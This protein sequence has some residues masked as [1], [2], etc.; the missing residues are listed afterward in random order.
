MTITNT[1]TATITLKPRMALPFFSRH[2]WVFSKPIAKIDGDPQPGE[3]VTLVTHDGQFVARGLFNPHSA[4]RVRLYSW[5]PDEALDDDF[6]RA[7][8]I[9][10]VDLRRTLFGL[11]STEGCRLVAS[12]GDRL[13]GLTVDRYGE[14]LVVQLTSR[15][16][17]ERK[18]RLI[19]A[20]VEQV[21]PK[22]IWLRT[23]KGMRDAE[24]LDASDGL[25]WGEAPPRPMFLEENDVRFGIDLT[26]GQKT[27][28]FLDQRDNR[29]LVRK[30]ASGRRVLDLCCYSGGFAINAALG[31]AAEVV[32]VDVSESALTLAANNAAL[33]GVGDR[34]RW[35]KGDAFKTLEALREEEKTFDLIVLDPPKLARHRAG[36]D[37]AIRG[38][39]SLNR[40]AVDLVAPGGLLVTCSC[41][42]LV[43]HDMF[44]E[45][46]SKVAAQANRHIQILE[47]RGPSADHPRSV[48]CHES[49]YLKCYVCRVV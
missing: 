40:L 44:C 25:L 36:L 33:N 5:N 18:D 41:S 35:R 29:Q 34:I 11:S 17:A 12:E 13:S 19:E 2:P 30:L 4:I 6:W 27:G 10:A 39:H 37:S 48:H 22:G 14:F 24:Q 47:A 42:G 9:E 28:F 7:R 8:V 21:Q 31:G 32:G 1:S 46:L 26:E 38:Y 23:E 3:E 45:I 20:L 16:L 15:A 43:S 49:D